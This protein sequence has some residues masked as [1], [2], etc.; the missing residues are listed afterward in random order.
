MQFAPNLNRLI[1]LASQSAKKKDQN[2]NTPELFIQLISGEKHA[3]ILSKLG[4]NGEAVAQSVSQIGIAFPTTVVGEDAKKEYE[5]VIAFAAQIS[6]KHN[7][8]FIDSEHVMV[9][10]LEVGNSI[11]AWMALIEEQQQFPTARFNQ[12]CN[13]L[14][15]FDKPPQN[16]Q[17]NEDFDDDMPPN[18][19]RFL[20]NITADIANSGQSVFGREKEITE[21]S[22]IVTRQRKNNALLIGDEGVGRKSICRGLAEKIMFGNVPDHLKFKTVYQLDCQ[23]L[24]SGTSMFGAIEQR[25]TSLTDELESVAG[26]DSII[27][28]PSLPTSVGKNQDTSL[29][30]LLSP[31]FESDK[32]PVILVCTQQEYKR[33]EKELLGF[34]QIKVSEPSK[35]ETL[36]IVL[37][38]IWKMQAHHMVSMDFDAVN[39][40]IDLCQRFLPYRKFPEKALDVLD[41]ILADTKNKAYTPPES[42]AKIENQI[43]K[44]ALSCAIQ[45]KSEQ[46]ARKKVEKLEDK[47]LAAK[48]R[49][50][51]KVMKNP[52]IVSV[53]QAISAFA[54]K[55]KLTENQIYQTQGSLLSDLADE[56]KKEVFGQEHV[57]DQVS[58]VL[59]CTKVGL[60]D[61]TKPIAKFMFAGSSGCGKT[62]LGK[63][64]AKHY[65]G[66]E[67]AYIKVDM[68]EFQERG[69]I[70]GLIGTTAGYIG[71]ENGGRLTEFVKHNPSCVVIFDEIEKAHPDVHNLLLQIMDDGCLT[72]GGGY[73]VDF[74]NTIII[75]TTNQGSADNKRSMGFLN[76]KTVQGNYAESI[77]KAFKPEIIGRIDEVLVFNDIDEKTSKLI[78][79]DSVNKIILAL[80]DQNI[81]LTVEEPVVDYLHKIVS[82]NQSHAR[83]VQSSVQ[84][85]LTTPISKLLIKQRPKAIIASIEGGLIKI[86]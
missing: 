46:E 71:Y 54:E 28:I 34:E 52:P 44:I 76:D 14:L 11:R 51:S 2:P 60:R 10:I 48:E 41:T 21:L 29:L 64:I 40:V 26:G 37:G 53:K 39:T 72:D 77:K 31:L 1:L 67:K 17:S 32:I 68:S 50:E 4:L 30:N 19:Q 5:E 82:E 13:K 47:F 79:W 63:K 55:Y 65:F 27:V 15:E 35:D 6:E 86:N 73:K 33:H 8:H 12:E 3:R 24:V 9:A 85:N 22:N 66:D 38:N 84:K 7:H 58:D 81:L 75:L 69:T 45:G 43:T 18:M 74:T 25:I 78:I 61:V 56:F 83:A 62:M 80:K 59:L 70:S 20:H 23:K 16:S 42:I 49:W 36:K 57:I